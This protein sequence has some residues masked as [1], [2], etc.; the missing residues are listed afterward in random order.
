MMKDRCADIPVATR[1][2]EMRLCRSVGDI[3][4]VTSGAVEVT[5]VVAV[6]LG[7][8]SLQAEVMMSAAKVSNGNGA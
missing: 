4:L 5:V 6:T 1:E 3:V 2:Y 8:A 7:A